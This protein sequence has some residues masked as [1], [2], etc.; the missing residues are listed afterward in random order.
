MK[1]VSL[2]DSAVKVSKWF[3]CTAAG[4]SFVAIWAKAGLI[5]RYLFGRPS[6]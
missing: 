4:T 1:A 3:I 6:A 5:E 2:P